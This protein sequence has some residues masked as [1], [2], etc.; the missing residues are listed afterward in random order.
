MKIHMDKIEGGP[1]HA[2]SAKDV[3]L[4]LK[5]VPSNWKEGMKEV[6][7]S[8]SLEWRGSRACAFF[9]RYDGCMTICCRN[10]SLEE[11]LN[12]VLSELAAVALR[13]NLGLWE[14][15]KA[16]QTRLNKIIKPLNQALLPQLHSK[17]HVQKRMN[18]DGFRELRFAPFP[19]DAELK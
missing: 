16:T 12:A 6:H 5:A 10:A 2:L 8:N 11:A 7:I 14:R 9:S 13:L 19:N 18:L 1:P 17:S 15:R 4:I 3:R